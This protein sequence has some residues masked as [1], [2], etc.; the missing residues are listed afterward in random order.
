V[1]PRRLR[2]RRRRRDRPYRL[3]SQDAIALQY[4]QQRLPRWTLSRSPPVS[5]RR[6]EVSRSPPA[7]GSMPTAP[8]R[9]R[10][11]CRPRCAPRSDPLGTAAS[12]EDA[13]IPAQGPRLEDEAYVLEVTPNGSGSTR[14]RAR[15][16]L[17]GADAAAAAC[18]GAPPGRD[19]HGLRLARLARAAGAHRGRA[20]FR[21]ARAHARHRTALLPLST[22]C[23]ASSTCSR[24]T[25]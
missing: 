16:A 17:G 11:S 4:T 14:R 24:C 8:R 23:C 9:C 12:A 25:G 15:S 19:R 2:V 7:C 13:G 3:V 1:R 18:A 6:P 22:R 20:A 10:A 5:R 21:L